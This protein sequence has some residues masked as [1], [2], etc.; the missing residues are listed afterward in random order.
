MA[1]RVDATVQAMQASRSQAPLN[2]FLPC[3]EREQLLPRH[4]PMLPFRQVRN[5]RVRGTRL[6][7][8]FH[9]PSKG[10]RVRIRPSSA[11]EMAGTYGP[12]VRSVAASA[13]AA[14]ASRI[15]APSKALESART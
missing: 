12:G 8:P 15:A 6:L 3:P 7:Q 4:H 5:P 11:T 2:R 9:S 10:R 14:S 1:N 13:V